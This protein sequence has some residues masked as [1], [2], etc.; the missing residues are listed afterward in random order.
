MDFSRSTPEMEV[1]RRP[2]KDAKRR[3]GWGLGS[4]ET[5]TPQMA[6]TPSWGI[7]VIQSLGRRPL[8]PVAVALSTLAVG[9][10]GL[11]IRGHQS[12]QTVIGWRAQTLARLHQIPRQRSLHG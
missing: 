1:R 4:E 11:G 10:Q 6:P 5:E 2:A 12:T 3:R 8:A 9:H 7:A